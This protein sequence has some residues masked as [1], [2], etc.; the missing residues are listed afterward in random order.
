MNEPATTFWNIQAVIVT[1]LRLIWQLNLFVAFVHPDHD[2]RSVSKFVNHLLSSGW[3]LSR[4]T[5]LFLNFGDLVIG[6]ANLVVGVH[7]SKQSR[8]E[9]IS[10]RVPPSP[11]PLPLAAYIREPF[12]KPEYSVS[13]TKDNDSFA[14][15]A[16]HGITATVPTLLVLASLPD[17]VQPLYYLHLRDSNMAML[18]GAAVMSLDSLCPAFNGFPNTNLFL[19]WFGIEYHVDNHACVRAISP[20]EFMSCFGLTDHLRYHLSQHVNW[21]ALDAGIPALTS[22]WIFDHVHERLGEIRDSNTEIFPPRQYAAPAVHVQAFI[23]GVVATCIPDHTHWAQAIASNPELSRIKE[24][25]ANPSKLNNKE[26][27]DIN[28]NYHAALRKL[29]IVL[30]D[31]VLIYRKP[32]A[33]SGSYTCLQL[34]PQHFC[35]ILFIAFHAN[36]VGGHL[37]PYRT[38]HCLRL[39]YYWPG[40]YSYVK[41]MCSTC[42][43]CALS[44]HT[45]AKSSELGY[46]FPIEAPFMVL[47]VD[48]HM[49]GAHSGFE[50]SKTYIIACCGMCTFGA[51]EPII[52]ANAT[53]FTSA[54]MKI[55]YTRLLKSG[56]YIIQISLYIT[57]LM[58][59]IYNF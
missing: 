10:F 28:Y 13:F 6:R 31:N 16:N 30:E 22:A 39:Q 29:L 27:A 24:I 41:R 42:P 44:N 12:N 43:G 35:N 5:C 25:V 32:L 23:S 18:A 15:N 17:G 14:T 3:V 47:H 9:P 54:I 45:K 33:G 37:N 34:V 36:L 53:T 1:Q 52:G 51:L 7:D 55:C 48:A 11:T 4:T 59:I 38:L 40:M 50:G 46:N 49:A 19:S 56:L 26:L 57:P 2:G 58:R 8:T 21:Y 20:F